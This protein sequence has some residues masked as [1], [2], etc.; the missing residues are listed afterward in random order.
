MLKGAGLREGE[1]AGRAMSDGSIALAGV[2][3]RRGGDTHQAADLH[4]RV[5]Q[6]VATFSPIESAF[7]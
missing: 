3:S 4:G 2:V 5:Q 7:T 1:L 6:R